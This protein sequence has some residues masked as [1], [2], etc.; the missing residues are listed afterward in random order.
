MEN[1]KTINFKKNQ[2]ICVKGEENLDLYFINSGKVM[3]FGNQ[4]T[5]VTPFAVINEKEFLGEFSYLDEEPRSSHLI[6]IEPTELVVI[7]AQ[8][9]HDFFPD[10]LLTLA[11]SITGKIRHLNHVIERKGIRKKN[12]ETVK[13][14]SID[15][16]RDYYAILQKAGVS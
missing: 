3:A 4:G 16:Q 5:K 15:E 8:N 6:C 11:H 1:F 14:L 7:P 9:I 12:V 10:W 2:L 13:P